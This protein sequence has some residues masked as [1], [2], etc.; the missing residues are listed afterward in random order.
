[1]WRPAKI[2][3]RIKRNDKYIKTILEIPLHSFTFIVF[4]VLRTSYHLVTM[5]QFQA[6]DD[7]L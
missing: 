1:M 7:Y 4:I 2:Y 3:S 6:K 5:D